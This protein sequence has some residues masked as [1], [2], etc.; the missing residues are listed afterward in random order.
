MRRIA[1]TDSNQKEI[2]EALRRSGA[3]VLLTHQLKNCFDCL[4]CHNGNIYMVEI[5]DGSL[6]PSARKLT[7]GEVAFKEKV[8]AVGCVYYVI[9]SVDEA[10]A[11]LI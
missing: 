11:M 10:L 8:E 7:S 9:H 6:P 4:V 3:V 5:K 1:R 2:V